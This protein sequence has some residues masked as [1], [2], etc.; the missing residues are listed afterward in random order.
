[1]RERSRSTDKLIW[2]KFFSETQVNTLPRQAFLSPAAGNSNCREV[3]GGS[4][5]ETTM[6]RKLKSGEMLRMIGCHESLLVSWIRRGVVP[7][8]PKDTAGNYEWGPNDIENV[9]QV[10]AAYCK[11]K[12]K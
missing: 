12:K 5:Q 2:P 8:P 6:D 4:N 1:M 10:L 7:R 3:P 11:S 9:R